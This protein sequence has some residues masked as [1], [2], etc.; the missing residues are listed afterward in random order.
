MGIINLKKR[1]F[2]QTIYFGKR[3]SLFFDEE[4]KKSK[5]RFR[6][7]GLLSLAAIGVG[8]VCHASMT[9]A[10]PNQIMNSD[11]VKL[12]DEQEADES[13]FDEL[14]D[15]GAAGFKNEAGF[16]E[17]FNNVS[18]RD[19]LLQCRGLGL[20]C[21]TAVY[22]KP[23]KSCYVTDATPKRNLEV[24]KQKGCTIHVRK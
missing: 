9:G 21:M 1:K 12:F 10:E 19:C 14:E 2:N 11:P 7:I 3:E 13:N 8:L 4:Q 6:I 22:C 20:N 5:K 23:Q 24:T 18:Q 15:K 16:L 17:T